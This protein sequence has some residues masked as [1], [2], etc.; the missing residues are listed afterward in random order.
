MLK[1]VGADLLSVE[2]DAIV[3]PADNRLS[4][5]YGL[6]K[7]IRDAAGEELTAACR[8][9][10]IEQRK[11]NLPPCPPMTTVVTPAFGLADRYKHILHTVGPD[12]R[13]PNQDR[14]RREMLPQAYQSLFDAVRDLDGV[15]TLVAP[16]IS[17]GTFVYPHREGARLSLEVLLT[18]LDGPEPCGIDEYIMVVSDPNF[19]SNMRAVYRETED[20]LPGMDVTNLP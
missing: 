14:D 8:A 20:Q 1:V 11:L 17:M 18:W 12:C 16:P 3:S 2:G 13:R 5:L 4:G 15:R 7:T 9:I 6:A 19:I 10:S